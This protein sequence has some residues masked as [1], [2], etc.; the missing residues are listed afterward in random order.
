M[1]TG[2]SL[3]SLSGKTVTGRLVNARRA[4]D[5]SAPVLGG[6]VSVLP[7][8]SSTLGTASVKT[9]LS[10]QAATDDV[11][12]VS[13]RVE[14]RRNAGA[15]TL[16][17]SS[18]TVRTLDL[19][20][21][22]SGT[23]EFRVTPRDGAGNAGTALAS[24]VVTPLRYEES[25]TLAKRTGTWLSSAASTSSGGRS[26]YTTATGA[27][28]TLTFNGRTAALV[29]PMGPTRSS[30]KVY[31]DGVYQRTVS[32]YA[33]TTKPRAVVFTTGTLTYRTH[34]LKL[35]HARVGSRIR[36]EVDAFVVLR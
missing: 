11:G 25:T 36:G 1:S 33:S 35:V 24:R 5:F 8:G 2:V 7:L 34:T 28:M 27:T 21:A 22:L 17:T 26:L 10:W 12:P 31:V 6:G 30:F 14:Q 15:W 16:L 20:L 23:Y 9:R 29:A 19:V 18:T 13:Y 32:L 3:P 4:I